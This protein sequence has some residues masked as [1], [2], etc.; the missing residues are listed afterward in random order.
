MRAAWCKEASLERINRMHSLA[1]VSDAEKWLVLPCFLRKHAFYGLPDAE[2]KT[3]DAQRWQL[4]V[5]HVIL[6]T[7]RPVR[8]WRRH[9]IADR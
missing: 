6:E 2:E 3:H 7:P 9:R 1:R 5:V 4:K 8:A